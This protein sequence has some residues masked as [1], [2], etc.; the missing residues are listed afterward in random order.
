MPA[1]I[2]Q[3]QRVTHALAVWPGRAQRVHPLRN[4]PIVQLEIDVNHRQ[5]WR[6][7]A[8]T[9][10][11][12]WRPTMPGRADTPLT[13]VRHFRPCAPG[14]GDLILQRVRISAMQNALRCQFVRLGAT[15]RFPRRSVRTRAPDVIDF[16][17]AGNGDT[18]PRRAPS[19]EPLVRMTGLQPNVMP[20]KRA[21]I[22]HFQS[23]NH[24]N[25]CKRPSLESRPARAP[26]ASR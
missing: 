20:L 9:T 11:D 4:R 2:P 6:I 8:P 19:V 13:L 1:Q 15:R 16:L 22:V 25:R 17:P 18:R 14:A 7:S 24:P 3:V 10:A 21:A 23:C 12:R 5:S 26:V